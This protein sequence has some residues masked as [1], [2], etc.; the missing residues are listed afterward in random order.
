ME[1][2]AFSP[3]ATLWHWQNCGKLINYWTAYTQKKQHYTTYWKLSM[4]RCRGFILEGVEVLSTLSSWA[5]AC[6]RARSDS[7]RFFCRNE[8]DLAGGERVS[9]EPLKIYNNILMKI[10]TQKSIFFQSLMYLST[11]LRKAS[12][13]TVINWHSQKFENRMDLLSG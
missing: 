3:L 11:F 1:K 5:P 13:L 7:S 4:R 8:A 2:I 9:P 10:N 12:L 6:C